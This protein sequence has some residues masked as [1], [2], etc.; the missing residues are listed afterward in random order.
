M[1]SRV[2]TS[3]PS[4]PLE[5]SSATCPRW[6]DFRCCPESR[7]EQPSRSSTSCPLQSIRRRRPLWRRT[8]GAAAR[9]RDAAK[10]AHCSTA[11]SAAGTHWCPPA[12]RH[13]AAARAGV[14]PLCNIADVAAGGTVLE[15]LKEAFI[16][17][18]S[19]E[20]HVTLCSGNARLLH[21]SLFRRYR[22]SP[23]E[24][25]GPA[26]ACGWCGRLAYL[27]TWWVGSAE[28]AHWPCWY[29]LGRS[30]VVSAD[31][32]TELCRLFP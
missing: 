13:S 28:R 10:L 18:E 2:G 17:S 31:S 19:Q 25:A 30:L 5:S 32:R 3:P 6:L 23:R 29:D 21:A 11:A 16:S 7:L 14:R 27:L 26:G 22:E 8:T 1:L 4:C 9:R 24:S 12:W 15:G 20:M